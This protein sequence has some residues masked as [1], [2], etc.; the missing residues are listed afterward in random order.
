M[1]SK[2]FSAG[3]AGLAFMTAVILAPMFEELLFRGLLQSWLETL[4]E[5]RA[6]PATIHS[7]EDA[8]FHATTGQLLPALFSEPE[9]QPEPRSP[10]EAPKTIDSPPSQSPS[11]FW[12][13]IGLT[14]LV[15]ASVHAP[16]W[17]APIALFA[18]SLVIGTVYYRTGS[19]IAAISMHATFNGFSTLALFIEVLTRASHLK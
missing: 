2:E 14:S 4:F 18:L 11:R 6:I 7:Q 8:S 1:I 16:Q 9:C 15:F 12:L 17:P 5:R 13:A 3:I 19:L 10:Y